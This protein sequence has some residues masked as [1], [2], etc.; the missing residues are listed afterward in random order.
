VLTSVGVNVLPSEIAVAFVGD[1]F[2]GDDE[3]MTD[4]RMKG[5]LEDLG[6]SLVEMLKKTH[7]EIE[8][9]SDRSR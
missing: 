4:E 7:D 3:E 9:V 5:V 1:K 2:A 8:G 6:A